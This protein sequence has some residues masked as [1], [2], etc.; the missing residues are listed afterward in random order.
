M[1]AKWKTKKPFRITR[2]GI[3]RR[4]SSYCLRLEA[5]TTAATLSSIWIRNLETATT[6]R[7]GKIHHRTAQIIRAERIDENTDAMEFG[8]RIV[9]ALLIKDHAILQAGTA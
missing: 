4:F 6:Q 5:F 1:P 3:F 7:V 9:R 8:A 2:N